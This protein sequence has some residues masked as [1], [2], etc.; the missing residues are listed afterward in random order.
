MC[1]LSN[2]RLYSDFKM[3]R[4]I[5]KVLLCT[6]LF[7]NFVCSLDVTIPELGTIQGS[8][9]SS[10][11]NN[12]KIYQ[13]LGVPYAE[14]PIDELRFKVVFFFLCSIIQSHVVFYFL[15]KS[16]QKRSFLLQRHSMPPN[17]V[18]NVPPFYR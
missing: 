18:D 15:I 1:I 7:C 10:V 2:Y 14:A 6:I 16:L 12:R 9:T 11:W 3:F 8:I 4:L 5:L 13:F 17:L